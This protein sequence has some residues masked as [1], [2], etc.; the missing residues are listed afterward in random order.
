MV[1]TYNIS[2]EKM[3]VDIAG[4]I[5]MENTQLWSSALVKKTVLLDMFW[6][7]SFPLKVSEEYLRQIACT[8][9]P[10]LQN[11]KSIA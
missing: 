7:L 9:I 10:L 4:Q 11:F 6:K 1:A 8:V 5:I 2:E 3:F